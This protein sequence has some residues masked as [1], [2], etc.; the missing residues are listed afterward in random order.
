MDNHGGK[1]FSWGQHE[2]HR[3]WGHTEVSLD[4]TKR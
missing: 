3:A 2:Y 4:L 1:A